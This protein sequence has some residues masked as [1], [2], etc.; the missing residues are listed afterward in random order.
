M[1]LTRSFRAFSLCA[2][3]F[4]CTVSPSA[5]ARMGVYLSG[6]GGVRAV[7]ERSPDGWLWTACEDTVAGSRWAIAGPRFSLQT[8]DGNRIGLVRRGHHRSRTDPLGRCGTGASSRNVLFSSRRTA[9]DLF[10]LCG[11]THPAHQALRATGAP[12]TI[13]RVGLLEVRSKGS[14]SELTGPSHVSCPVFGNEIFAG[15]E[16]PSAWCQVD[17]DT[18]YLAQRIHTLKSP[19]HGRSSR[20][21]FSARCP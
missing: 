16:H 15:V 9:A 21:L 4:L 5:G 1:P 8:P 3:T 20:R 13:Q 2:L 19:T 6:G 11:R 12:V 17:G 7:F 10:V 14:R 18:L